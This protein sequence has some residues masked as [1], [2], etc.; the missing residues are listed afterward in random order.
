MDEHWEAITGTSR[1]L[2][3]FDTDNGKTQFDVIVVSVYLDFLHKTEYML[4]VPDYPFYLG[5]C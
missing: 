1:Y 4:V 3:L 5:H 2:S